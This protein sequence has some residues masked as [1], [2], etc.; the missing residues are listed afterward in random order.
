MND[1]NTNSVYILPRAHPRMDFSLTVI[2]SQPSIYTSQGS[3]LDAC[4]IKAL[5]EVVERAVSC[6]VI[7]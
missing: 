3:N 7:V 6:G 5:L 1:G 2:A 4:P